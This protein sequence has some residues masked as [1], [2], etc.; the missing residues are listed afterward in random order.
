MISV[1]MDAPKKLKTL[2][3]F[4]DACIEPAAPFGFC[5]PN[6]AEWLRQAAREWR[7][8]LKKQINDCK[9]DEYY[10]LQAF[11]VEDWIKHF[12]NLGND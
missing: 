7:K 1:N 10:S 8:E 5:N 6:T 9:N 11:A 12:F 2:Q 3:D 4:V